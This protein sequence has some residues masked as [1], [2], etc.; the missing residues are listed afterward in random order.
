MYLIVYSVF[1]ICLL[2]YGMTTASASSIPTVVPPSV[3]GYMALMGERRAQREFLSMLLNEKPIDKERIKKIIKLD[4]EHT[5]ILKDKSAGWQDQLRRIESEPEY[6]PHAANKLNKLVE[7]VPILGRKVSP[8]VWLATS[9]EGHK[10]YLVGTNHS[11]GIRHLSPSAIDRLGEIWDKADAVLWEGGWAGSVYKALR[12]HSYHDALRQFKQL[13]YQ[14]LVFGIDRGDKEINSLGDSVGTDKRR[15]LE[16]EIEER[17]DREGHNK[18]V[19]PR[20]N[21]EDSA[22]TDDEKEQYLEEIIGKYELT[23]LKMTSYANYDVAGL[24]EL[25][26]RQR[27]LY[28]A[29]LVM[30][31]VLWEEYLLDGRNKIFM[32]SIKNTFKHGKTFMIMSGNAHMIVD[33]ENV[34]S[35]VALLR[36]DGFQVELLPP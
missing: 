4:I 26:K 30:R 17:L 32:Q 18:F 5:S 29:H 27:E 10:L 7:K 1:L 12:E 13:D 31:D 36:E 33:N 6:I 14:I 25:N 24:A 2:H 11:L 34:S 23:F 28:R 19:D 16:R 3:T 8:P 35:I 21:K 20:K 15:Q 9:E 22:L